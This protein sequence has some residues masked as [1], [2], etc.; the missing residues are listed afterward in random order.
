MA[1]CQVA[2]VGKDTT[3]WVR[4][5]RHDACAARAKRFGSRVGEQTKGGEALSTIGT[6]H[7]EERAE[8]RDGPLAE[9]AACPWYALYTHSHSEQLVYEQLAAKGLTLLPRYDVVPNAPGSGASR[10]PCF[11]ATLCIVW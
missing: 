5:H 10:S 1:E 6:M 7:G 4:R 9:V 3:L 11:Q 8:Q 2:A